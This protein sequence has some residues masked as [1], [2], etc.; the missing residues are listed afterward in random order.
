M[1]AVDDSRPGDP[2]AR[3]ARTKR[4]RTRAA[5]LNAADTA[6]GTRGWTRTRMEDVALEARVS[7]ATAYNHF[8][9]KHVLIGHVYRPLVLPLLVQAEQDLAAGRPVIDALADQVRAL[10][11]TACRNGI[12]SGAYFAACQEYAARVHAP[13]RLDDDLDPRTLA[14]VPDGIRLLV[15]FGQ[16][17]GELRRFPAAADISSMIANLVLIRGVEAPHE[18]PEITTE[19]LLTILFGALRPEKLLEG[20]TGC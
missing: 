3:A 19:L 11:R 6:F 7:A 13:A 9:T 2:R 17:V 10:V 16:Q 20:P 18:R 4:D 1:F 15:A 14:P 12:L 5:L 8:A